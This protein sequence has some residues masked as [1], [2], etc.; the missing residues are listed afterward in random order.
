MGVRFGT[1]GIRGVANAE[2][3]AELVLALG[4]AAARALPAPT[5][6][7]ARDTRQSGPLLQAALSAGLASEGADVVDLG[8][9]PT[10]GV[11][12]HCASRHL[13]GA[14]ISA[15]HN[16][17]ADNGVKLF[18]PGGLKLPDA[19]EAAVEEELDRVLAAE[20]RDRRSPTGRAVGRLSTDPAA[21][22]GYV[23]H[24]VAALE[25][26][27]LEGMRVVVDCANGAASGIAP[28][29]L[30]RLGA[31]VDAIACEPDGT[32][33]NEGCGST[34][35]ERV[36]A[37]VVRRG[38]E[39]G[40]ALDGD[41]DRLVAVDHTGA[42][43][44]G[45]ELLA[46]FATD[47][48]QRGR[49]AGNTVVVTVMSNLGF[50]LAMAERNIAVRE[51]PI[52]DRYVLEELNAE[53]LTLGGEQSGHLVFRERA[54][55]G[56]GVLTAVL[57]LDLLRRTGR[58]L[59]ELAREAMHRLPQ[60]L[61]NVPA[62]DPARVVESAEV[63]AEVAAVTLELGDGG[64]ILLRP[65]GTEPL[66]RVMVEAADQDLAHLVVARL[67]AVVERAASVPSAP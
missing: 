20:V 65:S 50:R 58:P 55:T 56:D 59:E 5:F 43:T 17:F 44:T 46:L 13:P 49:L 26:R 2:L 24:L 53:G 37:E 21:A 11:A 64:R 10:P 1:D 33:I 54:T 60:I 51:T 31:S 48:A 67:S 61:V 27:V 57:L 34:H 4:R 52:G 15:S 23:E 14:V 6:L 36:G 29:V 66:V 63:Q 35:P 19:A 32:N 9:L 38:A 8:V 41:A 7:V 12:W 16:P 25:G 42:A 39:I 47:L 28:V 30:E 22:D 45:D 18:A 40:L 62:V 3:G